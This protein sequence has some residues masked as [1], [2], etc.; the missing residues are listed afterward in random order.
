MGGSW[1]RELDRSEC[2]QSHERKRLRHDS[3]DVED[4]EAAGG[5]LV[6]FSRSMHQRVEVES[7]FL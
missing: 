4:D 1:G 6:N 2:L 3:G 7:E 5:L